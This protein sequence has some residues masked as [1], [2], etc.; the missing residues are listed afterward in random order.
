M[1]L[2]KDG[3]ISTTKNTLLSPS[4]DEEDLFDVPPDL[5][6][7]P[8]KEDSLFDQAPILSPVQARRSKTH[9]D[10]D[11]LHSS[12]SV[13]KSKV[14]SKNQLKEADESRKKDKEDDKSAPIDPLRDDNHDPLKDPSQLFAF[15]TKTPSPEK[16]QG[17]LFDEDDSLFSTS[18]TEAS[19]AGSTAAS[20]GESN[21]K[22]PL[23]LF[24]DDSASDLFSGP[25]TKPVK[26]PVK[27]SAVKSSL[28]NDF[29]SED[30]DET[31]DLFASVSSRKSNQSKSELSDAEISAKGNST[32]QAD[33]FEDDE[34][35]EEEL[36]FDASEKPSSDSSKG[37]QSPA[38]T[39]A[40]TTVTSGSKKTKLGDIFGD[41]SSGEDDIFFTKKPIAKDKA[42]SFFSNEGESDDDLFAIKPAA[43]ANLSQSADNQAPVKKSVTRDLKKTAEA[44]SEDP[45][46][47]LHDD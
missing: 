34:D 14:E 27:G 31:E 20:I 4:T 18:K 36:F 22:S 6:E 11:K 35:N 44:I 25:F 42:S 3:S 47:I 45:L 5:P 17:L 38:V 16:G 13:N 9:F 2:S 24:D 46:S 8:P 40:A 43:S 28:F 37:D 41:Q 33:G 12:Y 32:K 29:D 19:I 15:V 30:D 10:N 26:K 7:D 21:K 39:T 23:D 1:S